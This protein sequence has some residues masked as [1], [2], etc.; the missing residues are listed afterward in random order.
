MNSCLQVVGVRGV[1]NSPYYC[2]P[3]TSNG[4][5]ALTARQIQVSFLAREGTVLDGTSSAAD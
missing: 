2:Y 4:N 1:C 5:M 3:H